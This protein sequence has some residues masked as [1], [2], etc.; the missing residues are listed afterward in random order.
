MKRKPR[1][2]LSKDNSHATS[3]A[4]LNAARREKKFR[5]IL[6]ADAT[7][8]PF[9]VVRSNSR[10]YGYDSNDD[11]PAIETLRIADE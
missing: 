4:R 9:V 8:D 2:H 11:A 10:R 3:N 5:G 7:L 1:P 6:S